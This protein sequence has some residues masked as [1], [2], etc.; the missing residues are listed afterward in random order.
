MKCQEDRNRKW[1][2][3][4]TKKYFQNPFLTVFEDFYSKSKK[5]KNFGVI[6]EEK[7]NFILK[8]DFNSLI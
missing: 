8:L 3:L 5:E 2:I 4:I 6:S 1:N 7:N